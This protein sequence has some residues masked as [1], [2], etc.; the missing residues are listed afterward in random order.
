LLSNLAASYLATGQVA[1]RLGNDHPNMVPYGMYAT[2]DGAVNLACSHDGLWRRFCAVMALD[3]YVD[4]PRFRANA[5][6]VRNR[7]EL[8]AILEPCVGALSTTEVLRR[9]A[10]A[11]IPAGP[12]LDVGQVLDDPQTRAQ[13]LR[14]T[15]EHGTL[16]PIEVTGPAYHFSATPATIRRA[17]PAL[18]EHTNEVLRDL[19]YDAAA[20]AEL[21]AKGVV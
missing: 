14:Q 2:A 12:I 17:P 21:R 7:T 13:G 16:G 5:D 8:A 10:E 15:V 1:R 9:M 11:G 20:I 3:A 19:G 18:G 4:D 6:R